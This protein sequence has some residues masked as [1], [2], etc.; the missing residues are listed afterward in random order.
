MPWKALYNVTMQEYKIVFS[1][2]DG[3]LLNNA[4]RVPAATALYLRAL[5]ARGVPFVIVTARMPAAALPLQ[6]EI[7][8]SSPM[9]CYGGALTLDK[10]LNPLRS[11]CLTPQQSA[12]V[13]AFAKAHFPQV[14]ISLYAGNDWYAF[15]PQA[16]E[17]KLES[18]I[19]G[20]PVQPVP[21]LYNK[22]IYP[23]KVFFIT[24]D[25]DTCEQ[26]LQALE[27]QFPALAVSHSGFGHIEVTAA[28]AVK[29]LAMQ[30]LCQTLGIDVS[31]A[32]AFGDSLNDA[33]M[34]RAAGLG[35]AV[36]NASPQA[37]AAAKRICPCN[38]Q[39]GVKQTLQ[40]L[41]A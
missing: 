21:P 40:E 33:D 9:I 12:A 32:I 1:D 30:S 14:Q 25:S 37:K 6:R 13:V 22:N 7:G 11:L 35:V 28:N 4:H 36:E 15:N 2:L 17:I 19:T 29:A 39:E 8:I 3:T 20:V 41:F 26:M 24:P 34:L 10:D 23:H 5:V 31:S 38:E 18:Q 27:Q 16:P